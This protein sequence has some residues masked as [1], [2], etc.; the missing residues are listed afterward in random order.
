MHTCFHKNSV[1]HHTYHI[2][3]S[4]L[5]T[6]FVN[7]IYVSIIVSQKK[8]YNLKRKYKKNKKNKTI[9]NFLDLPQKVYRGLLI[10]I[11]IIMVPRLR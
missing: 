7:M 11:Y 2:Y 5:L 6:W 8:I 3:L 9:D 4:V 1:Y 10:P